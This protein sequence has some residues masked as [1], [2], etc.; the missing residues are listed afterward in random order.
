ML[1]KYEGQ[2]LFFSPC[3]QKMQVLILTF[4]VAMVGR[5]VPMVEGTILI[6]LNVS[7]PWPTRTPAEEEA[8]AFLMKT[9]TPEVVA[10]VEKLEKVGPT[11]SI[12]RHV[13]I[14]TIVSMG[15][16]LP[17]SIQLLTCILW[18]RSH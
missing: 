3:N 9:G 5:W 8:H 2:A 7:K 12:L 11:L 6:D 16:D 1:K 10:G 17:P 15:G 4:V 18:W 13:F 14:P